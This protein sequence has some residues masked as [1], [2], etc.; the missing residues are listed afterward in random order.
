MSCEQDKYVWMIILQLWTK[1]TNCMTTDVENHKKRI[2]MPQIKVSMK[3]KF[4]RY[5]FQNVMFE[6]HNSKIWDAYDKN[7]WFYE[8]AK[9]S[10]FTFKNGIWIARPK[11]HVTSTHDVSLCV[12]PCLYVAQSSNLMGRIWFQDVVV[13]KFDDCAMY[14][15]NYIRPIN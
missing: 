11:C 3:R 10:Y 1:L 2:V 8:C 14:K 15:S 13:I 6:I 12:R 7:C 9:L 4:F 5:N